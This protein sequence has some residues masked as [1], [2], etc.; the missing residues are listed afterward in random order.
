MVV[1]GSARWGGRAEPRSIC[2]VFRYLKVDGI[3]VYGAPS[4]VSMPEKALSPQAEELMEYAKSRSHMAFCRRCG[5]RM[6]KCATCIAVHGTSFFTCYRCCSQRWGSHND[7][8]ESKV[9]A[10]GFPAPLACCYVSNVHTLHYLTCTHA[11]IVIFN[12]TKL[13]QPTLI[14]SA[15]RDHM[16]GTIQVF[17]RFIRCRPG[18][19]KTEEDV[20]MKD[21]SGSI[22]CNPSQLCS[23]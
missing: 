2:Q 16:P 8:E 11:H 17:A 9:P 21:D 14:S 10:F 7:F 18:K 13:A 19:D 20:A 12:R 1:W 3:K 4:S 5:I 23:W 15:N 6:S 22:S